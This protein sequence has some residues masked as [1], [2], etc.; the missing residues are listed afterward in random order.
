MCIYN[1][2]PLLTVQ[3]SLIG[4]TLYEIVGAEQQISHIGGG[5][6]Q[7]IGNLRIGHFAHHYI[8][9]HE[10]IYI[11]IKEYFIPFGCER[12]AFYKHLIGTNLLVPISICWPGTA[13]SAAFTAA[14]TSASEAETKK[15]G[16]SSCTR[17]R[18]CNWARLSSGELLSVPAIKF[19]PC[20]WSVIVGKALDENSLCVHLSWR[21]SWVRIICSLSSGVWSEN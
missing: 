19:W 17:L 21:V 9:V 1:N 16:R 2:N 20:M 10:E 18:D 12:R 4:G 7:K 6:S 15:P 5:S 13:S 14:S 3:T 11:Q 8:H